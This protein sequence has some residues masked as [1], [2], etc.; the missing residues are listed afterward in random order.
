MEST[1]T[2]FDSG[3]NKDDQ[4]VS[5]GQNVPSGGIKRN[6][7]SVLILALI[8]IFALVSVVLY[9]TARAKT[10]KSLDLDSQ[11]SQVNQQIKSKDQLERAVVAIYGQVNNLDTVINKRN[12]WS[13]LLTQISSTSDKNVQL[14]SITTSDLSSVNI[15]GK[16]SSYTSLAYYLKRLENSTKM[17]NISLVSSNEAQDVDS[18]KVQFAI[19][20]SILESIVSQGSSASTSSDQSQT[21]NANSAPSTDQGTTSETPTEN[22]GE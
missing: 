11:I 5:P 8:I 13:K 2:S 14:T 7:F 19:N 15:S 9:I 18:V 16:A 10:S 6:I 21:S 4:V 1:P 12:F 22:T 17:S 3:L 20:A